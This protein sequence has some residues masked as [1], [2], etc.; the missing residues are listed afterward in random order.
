MRRPET[1]IR[2]VKRR[3][4][5]G[6]DSSSTKVLIADEHGIVRDGLRS[7]L[8]KH[9][10]MRVIATA[11]DGREAVA[12]AERFLPQVVI[13]EFN[14]RLLN[15]IDATRAITQRKPETGVIILSMQDSGTLIQRALQAGARGYLTKH[16][17]GEEL[18]KAVREVAAGKRYLGNSVADKVF[19]TLR[20]PGAG[21]LEDLTATERDI[22]GL[23]ADG[24][25]NAEVAAQLRLSTRT[26]ETYR[27]RLMRKLGIDDLPS[28]VK[29]AI[30]H[31]ITALD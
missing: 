7:L 22:L 4:L 18:V 27:I 26:V 10:D 6:R 14:L 15:G 3:R 30:R 29:L 31:G 16:T 19:D 20:R 24:K 5:S 25:S 23:V 13:M 28:L 9:D 2:R 1:T 12:A 11:H 21:V 8:E 17:G